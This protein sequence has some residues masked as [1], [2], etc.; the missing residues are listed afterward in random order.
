MLAFYISLST[1]FFLS[2]KRQFLRQHRTLLGTIKKKVIVNKLTPCP[3]IRSGDIIG[4][5]RH[6]T[7]YVNYILRKLFWSISRTLLR[8][9]KY[10]S[11]SRRVYLGTSIPV[12]C[13]TFLFAFPQWIIKEAKLRRFTIFAI[14][15][16]LTRILRCSILGVYQFCFPSP[17]G[18]SQKTHQLPVFVWHPINE[19]SYPL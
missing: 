15:L 7:W 13:L 4:F 10:W 11:K 9:C 16:F 18:T 8:L 17:S 1:S 2:K 6:W 3:F 14:R 19:V 12:L 5:W